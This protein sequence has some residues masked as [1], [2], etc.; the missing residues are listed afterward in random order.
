MR[1][2]NHRR[3]EEEN[4]NIVKYLEAQKSSYSNEKIRKDYAETRRL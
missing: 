1:L 2:L 4:L 3:I